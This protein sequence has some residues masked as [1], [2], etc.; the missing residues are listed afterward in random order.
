MRPRLVYADWLDERRDPELE[1]Q[2][3][4]P[5]RYLASLSL[6]RRKAASARVP[7]R[8]AISLETHMDGGRRQDG[9]RSVC[10]EV[11]LRCPRRWER[12]TCDRRCASPPLWRVPENGP[13]LCS[14]MT[15]A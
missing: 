1:S 10:S 2:G 8:A 12:P 14:L 11:P 4:L 15:D 13:L 6:S 7:H 3:I 5:A 9:Y